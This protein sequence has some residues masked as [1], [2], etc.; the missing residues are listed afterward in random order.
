MIKRGDRR[1]FDL[2]NYIIAAQ[3]AY[4]PGGNEMI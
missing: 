2:D 1:G 3:A 4:L